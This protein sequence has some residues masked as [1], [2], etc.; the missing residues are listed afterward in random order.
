MGHDRTRM[1]DWLL[2]VVSNYFVSSGQFL[3]G[4]HKATCT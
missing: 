2:F 1:I 3:R 4:R